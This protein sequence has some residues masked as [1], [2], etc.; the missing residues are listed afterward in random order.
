M[1]HCS[2]ILDEWGGLVVPEDG[3]AESCSP[4]MHQILLRNTIL[5]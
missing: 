5:V 2:V 3:S 4:V 1:K